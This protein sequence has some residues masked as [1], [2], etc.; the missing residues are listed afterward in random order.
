MLSKSMSLVR[1]W[2]GGQRESCTDDKAGE[3]TK[4][5]LCHYCNVNV[6][7]S[8]ALYFNAVSITS[9]IRTCWVGLNVLVCYGTHLQ[10]VDF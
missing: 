9:C 6:G 10:V 3:D 2:C 7:I 8:A 5:K 1:T 4:N